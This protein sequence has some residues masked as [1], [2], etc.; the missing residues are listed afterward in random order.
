MCDN[1]NEATGVNKLYNYVN[2]ITG[3]APIQQ[4]Y[5]RQ[6]ILKTKCSKLKL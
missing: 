4:R 1:S 2:L 6:L 3:A 5:S